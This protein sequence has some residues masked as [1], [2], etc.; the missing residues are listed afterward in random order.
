MINIQYIKENNLFGLND[1]LTDEEHWDDLELIKLEIITNILNVIK[2]YW[3]D[4]NDYSKNR[5]LVNYIQ[6]NKVDKVIS[7]M[8]NFEK[9]NIEN[10][11]D[12]VMMLAKDILAQLQ[13]K[14]GN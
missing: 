9:Y 13:T 14:T 8:N 12:S 4:E 2:Y 10:Y 1:T 6:E 5:L 7:N 3:I 11:V